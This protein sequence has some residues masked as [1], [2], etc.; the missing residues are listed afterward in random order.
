[1]SLAEV[2]LAMAILSMFTL[3]IATVIIR[4][5]DLNRRDAEVYQTTM[6]CNE[7]LE[8]AMYGAST[9]AGFD[10][11]PTYQDYTFLKFHTA[12]QSQYI[13]TESVNSLAAVD[14]NITMKKVTVAIYAQTQ[15]G[16]AAVPAPDLSRSRNGKVVQM[17]TVVI[18]PGQE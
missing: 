7:L 18:K 10:A 6:F 9:P 17:S 11:L 15:T 8:Q 16:P 2:L 3:A 4:G 1:M 14:G 12:A 5:M 13:Y